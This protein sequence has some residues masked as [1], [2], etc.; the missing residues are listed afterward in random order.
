VRHTQRSAALALLLV[1]GATAGPAH[2]DLTTTVLRWTAPGDDG[3]V[4][5]A[6]QYDLRYSDRPIT[7][8]TFSACA[9]IPVFVQ[10]SAPGQTDSMVV[11]GLNPALTYYFAIKTCDEVGNW[12]ALSNVLVKPSF[13]GTTDVANAL[14]LAFSNPWPNPS[15]SDVRVAFTLPSDDRVSV[16]VF[17]LSGRLVQNLAHGPWRSGHSELAWDLTDAHG[18]HVAAGMYLI[19]AQLAGATF[20]RRC[21]IVR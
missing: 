12:S 8:A 9:H 17:D 5:R 4:G 3:M 7:A 21:V 11:S 10:P 1:L 20:T 6:T 14:T 2:A 16:D 18:R 13:Y 15:R 19:R